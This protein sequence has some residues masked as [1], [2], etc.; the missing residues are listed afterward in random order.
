MA[1]DQMDLNYS[2]LGPTAL[3]AYIASCVVDGWTQCTVWILLLTESC[4][5]TVIQLCNDTACLRP[6]R[7]SRPPWRRTPTRC[8]SSPTCTWST[9]GRGGRAPS[10]T[11]ATRAHRRAR[12]SRGPCTSR[13]WPRTRSGGMGSSTIL[14]L[15]LLNYVKIIPS[16]PVEFGIVLPSDQVWRR[17]RRRRGAGGGQRAWGDACQPADPTAADG[18]AAPEER[19]QPEEAGCPRIQVGS[20]PRGARGLSL[21]PSLCPHLAVGLDIHSIYLHYHGCH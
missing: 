6:R 5:P 1:A 9:H 18:D 12:P 13:R 10:P 15:L 21:P 20:C 17:R 3:E 2:L 16:H 7:R 8:S 19:G 14:L 4:Y 11:P